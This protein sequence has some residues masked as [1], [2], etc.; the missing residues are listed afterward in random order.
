MWF[1][2]FLVLFLLWF[3]WIGCVC[4]VLFT[5]VVCFWC[6][7]DLCGFL[8]DI[9]V[10]FSRLLYCVVLFIGFVFCCLI[11]CWCLCLSK[12]LRWF[13]VLA[14]CRFVL[15]VGLAF[16]GCGTCCFSVC[17]CYFKCL[18]VVYLRVTFYLIVLLYLDSLVVC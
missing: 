7:F 16:V 10:A 4:L 3:D 5:C 15:A 9:Y 1:V 17:L 6:V 2:H 8:L 13:A 11:A 18:F 14:V 12:C